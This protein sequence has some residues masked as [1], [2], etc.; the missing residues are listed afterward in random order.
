MANNRGGLS[1]REF[2]AKNA[3]VA[4]D[5]KKSAKEQGKS[6]PVV[7]PVAG[8]KVTYNMSNGQANVSSD[9][10]A[11]GQNQ[12]GSLI[13]D[14]PE[15]KPV[16]GPAI[17]AGFQRQVSAV[18]NYSE[19]KAKPINYTPAPK[20]PVTE[21]DNYKKAVA[22]AK[23]AQDEAK[24]NTGFFNI[25]KNTISGLSGA[26][27]KV[28]GVI[29][30][31][32]SEV[33]KPTGG[34][35]KFSEEDLNKYDNENKPSISIK[36]GKVINTGPS[37]LQSVKD[38]VN[39]KK[40]KEKIV[41][42][43]RGLVGIASGFGG[44]L[45]NVGTNT[46]AKIT[47]TKVGGKLAD[48]GSSIDAFYK[49]PKTVGEAANSRLAEQ[50]SNFVGAGV[51][52]SGKIS[53][54]VASAIRKAVAAGKSESEIAS[55]YKNAVSGVGKMVTKDASLKAA[56]NKKIGQ[57]VIDAGKTIQ[58]SVETPKA[59]ASDF[60]PASKDASLISDDVISDTAKIEKAAAEA[61]RIKGG[62][63]PKIDEPYV[64]PEKAPIERTKVA[65][66]NDTAEAFRMK[67][68]KTIDDS[69]N[70][71]DEFN[72]DGTM[73]PKKD[74]TIEINKELD[75][76]RKQ[77]ED[78]TGEKAPSDPDELVARIKA[79][80]TEN[81]PKW[82]K[83]DKVNTRNRELSSRA[84]VRSGQTYIPGSKRPAGGKFG[85]KKGILVQAR[86][87][88]VAKGK[89]DI[90]KFERAK[91]L[92]P[93]NRK[94]EDAAFEKI[95][96][97][98]SEI[99]SEYSKKNGKVVNADSFRPYFKE[100]GY[101]G[102]NAAAIQE[103]SSYLAKRAYTEGLKNDGEFATIY[104]GGSGTG[105]TSAV[106]DIPE[107]SDIIKNSA[108]ILDGNLSNYD[109]AIKKITEARNAGKKVPLI[110]TYR[111][112]EESFSEGVV[113]RMINN[114]DEMGRLVPS[115]VVAENHIGSWE[116]FKRL[117]SEGFDVKFVDNSLG[118]GNARLISFEDLNKKIKYPS[119]EKL[120]EQFNKKA[121]SL[122][123]GGT[124][125]PEQYKG[126]TGQVAPERG[127]LRRDGV[128]IAKQETRG[129]M[130]TITDSPK[131][132]EELKTLLD[133]KGL[134]DV[135][136]TNDLA[137]KAKNFVADY[138]N[139][140]QDIAR[141][142]KIDDTTGAVTMELIKKHIA[143]GNIDHALDLV[144][145]VA[146][147]FTQA[148]RFSQLATIYNRLTPE[149][150][151]RFAQ[152]EVNKANVIN[153]KLG[154]KIGQDEALRITE[155]AK[156]IGKMP[157]GD[158]KLFETQKLLKE[159]HT[160]IPSGTASK[161]STFQT[162]A[163]LLN[164]KTFIRNVAGNT[165]FS[166]IENIS[167]TVATPVDKFL[168]LF[169]GKRTT[170]LPNTAQF[171][172]AKKG[173][174]QGYKEAKEGI[175]TTSLHTQF[176]LNQ[177]PVFRDKILGNAE[178]LMRISLQ[179]T[180]RAAYQAAFDDTIKGL[181][182]TNGGKVT[183][184][185]MEIAHHNGMYRTFQDDSVLSKFFSELKQGF[186]KIGYTDTEGKRFG[187]GDL[188][189]KYP[190][191]PANLLNRGM[192]YSPAGF[193]RA[194][195]EGSKP[196]FGK[197]FNQKAFVDAFSK[198]T[199]GSAGLV[200]MGAY[201]ADVGIITPRPSDKA[202]VRNME[203]MQGLG[204][205]K[206]NVS[207]LKRFVMTGFNENSAKLREGDNLVSYDWAQPASL[208]LS[209]GANIV[210]NKDANKLVS[211][212][213]TLTQSI[214]EGSNTLAEQ[215]LLQGLQKLFGQGGIVAGLGETAKGSLASMVPTLLNQINQLVDNTSRE[216]YSNSMYQETL[217]RAMAK[218]PGLASM[219][220]AQVDVFG[221][222]KERYQNGSNS[223]VNVLLN[224]AFTSDFTNTPE[225][226]LV[227][228]IY[229]STGDTK[230]IPNIPAKKIKVNG[231]DMQLT[232]DQYV[233][234]EKYVGSR[235][236]EA[237]QNM[238]SDEEFMKLSASQ[239]ASEL[240]SIMTNIGKLA[241]RDLFGDT[242]SGVKEMDTMYKLREMKDLYTKIDSLENAGK[243][244][245][246][247][248]L[249]E[250]ISDEDMKLFKDAAKSIKASKTRELN[251]ELKPRMKSV[252]D[253]I[254]QLEN[255]GKYDESD[256]LFNRL[257]EDEQKVVSSLV[258]NN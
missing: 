127:L 206:I 10:K 112:P 63:A 11:I 86:A 178:K 140:S 231:E 137:V 20:K 56:G 134:Y 6:K 46:Q 8:K 238:A 83:Q 120:T 64:A 246:S 9:R 81:N 47:K 67:V 253:Q 169:S 71:K 51:T 87:N 226:K 97:K 212:L 209:I 66:L 156:K 122:Y 189:L 215:P 164:P 181:S 243:Y 61:D 187:L 194:I 15:A 158:A 247:D 180:D 126:Y 241:K 223:L 109:S 118:K 196:L 216:T 68:S 144:E 82:I 88:K 168:S 54:E 93:S 236:K 233:S 244:D 2:A 252:A 58:K 22:D 166:G 251:E 197:E 248:R 190:K 75:G 34:L 125:N 204:G 207:A 85:G 255:D 224:P 170:A 23:R 149:G 111:G 37:L 76:F 229:K 258:K 185:M 25:A 129:F 186:N 52:K 153:P 3:G 205:Y 208:G 99:L 4:T 79:I 72:P 49:N 188:I 191:T 176:D 250:N 132:P 31:V 13:Y 183:P 121:K 30:Q 57:D 73:K 201:L 117:H 150:I 84:G 21:S 148:G 90:S 192:A 177:V 48:V 130:E 19:E 92:D 163:Q 65:Q 199:T 193:V 230:Q 218:V 225:S 96:N 211:S 155:M 45:S 160:L 235:T 213:E 220:P 12:D 123:H 159:I 254:I 210:A 242:A 80:E 89:P 195:F 27:K 131:T 119:K 114:K 234:F 62:R 167:Q 182:K 28:G 143:D 179:S 95:Y 219:L 174:I 74:P 17:P 116:V 200:G 1:K 249:L 135:R 14:K 257:S 145:Q 141:S 24:K 240:S 162:I 41:G 33:I 35:G 228:D 227:M 107:L 203:R 7:Q 50:L 38:S 128:K 232:S 29:K 70:A 175:N 256:A 172:G 151:L 222:D 110:Y 59:L 103:P 154:L 100:E 40:V 136:N 171:S 239:K 101:A 173:L 157:E 16:Y 161:L 106:K 147:K 113:K 152:R 214:A 55:I 139:I 104:G 198:A 105:K 78:L 44:V 69:K 94:I 237:F 221:N 146:P 202:D 115:N 77:F 184:E 18:K 53:E 26:A 36:D 165:L 5:Y 60:T 43:A 39:P 124:I 142:G 32:G 91:G 108:V 245:E 217:N 133:G 98:E 102:H 138:P 42:G